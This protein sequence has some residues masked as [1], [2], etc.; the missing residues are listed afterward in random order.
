MTY[1]CTRKS[2]RWPR[3]RRCWHTCTHTQRVLAGHIT[4]NTVPEEV[5]G[6]AV[7][8]LTLGLALLLR[9][10]VQTHLITFEL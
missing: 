6:A 3:P 8:A 10:L 1:I 2:R 7:R 5:G 4:V 9:A